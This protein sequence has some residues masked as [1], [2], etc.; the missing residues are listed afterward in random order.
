MVLSMGTQPMELGGPYLGALRDSTDAIADTGVLRER[1]SEDGYLLLRGL[2]DRDAVAAARAVILGNLFSN[3][4]LD[5]ARP[6]EDA[7]PSVGGRGVFL[8]GAK[9]VTHTPE[10]LRVVEGP[11]LM[12]LFTRLLGGEPMTYPYKWVRVVGPGDFTGAHYDIVYMGRGTD[13]VITCWTPLGDISYQQGPLAVLAGSHRI[14]RLRETYGRMDVDRD[15]VAR[16]FF[17]EDPVEMVDTFGGRWLTAEF[18]AGDALLFGM[19]TMHGSLNNATGR[20]RI[21][22]D[23]RYQRAADPADERWVGEDPIAHYAWGKGEVTTIEEA[24][25]RWGV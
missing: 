16:G 11:E 9:A 10:F 14:D 15:N 6:M 25:R 20:Y 2:H 7:A 12:A 18:R 8:G 3:G 4:Q 5:A 24:R 22:C 19:Y 23:T 21:S 17:S 13:D 1:L